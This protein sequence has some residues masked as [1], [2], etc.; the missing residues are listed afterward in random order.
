MP[1]LV[2]SRRRCSFFLLLFICIPLTVLKLD[3]S[4]ENPG[5]H[6]QIIGFLLLS[7][8]CINDSDFK[9]LEEW[10]IGEPL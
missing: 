2:A 6:S 1:P 3:L 7:I 5:Y 10:F 4:W 8:N 9:L